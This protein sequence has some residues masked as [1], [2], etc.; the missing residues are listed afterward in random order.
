MKKTSALLL[1]V[2]D[3]IKRG[4]RNYRATCEGETFLEGSR[5]ELNFV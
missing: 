2:H 5:S 3:V 1:L 4:V